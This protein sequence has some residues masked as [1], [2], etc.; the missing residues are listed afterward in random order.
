MATNIIICCSFHS[1]VRFGTQNQFNAYFLFLNRNRAKKMAMM[2]LQQY[3]ELEAN[4]PN[5][6][7]NELASE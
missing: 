1:V 2:W 3:T 6:R 4:Q 7:I 5:E